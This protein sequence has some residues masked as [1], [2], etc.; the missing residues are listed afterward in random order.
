MKIFQYLFTLYCILTFFILL[1]LLGLFIAIP[2]LIHPKGG[3]VS[4]L[5]IRFWARAWS[6][7]SGI[8]YEFH[9]RAN[10]NPKSPYIY[11]FNHTSFIDAPIIPLTIPQQVRV[12]GKKELSKIPLFGWVLSRVAVWVDRSDTHSRKISVEQLIKFLKQG[13]SV[14]VSPE[15]TRNDTEELLFPFRRGAFRLAVETQT[16][17][18]PIAIIGANKIMKKGSWLIRPGKVRVYLSTPIHPPAPSEA[19]ID[20]LLAESKAQLEAMILRHYHPQD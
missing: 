19:A 17:I 11:I 14:V 5:F 20:E 12:I 4:F 16:P 8:N 6:T 13:I 9:G 2:L 18:A 1:L 10:L 7:L 3:E 15:G